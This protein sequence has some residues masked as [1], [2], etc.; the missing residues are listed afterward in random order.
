MWLHRRFGMH[1]DVDDLVQE[2]FLR[3]VK[4]QRL[5]KIDE[6]RP[7]LFA[8]AY[9][10]AIDLYRRR[11][12]LAVGGVAELDALSVV[13]EAGTTAAFQ[14]DGE[15]MAILVEAI[16]SLPRR[17]RLVLKLRK[18]RGLS[19]RDIAEQLG[20]SENTVHAHVEKGVARCR[21]YFRER[22]LLRKDAP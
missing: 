10:T 6:V 3:V 17:C 9:N 19:H 12:T 1:S 7:Y 16:E 4:G 20:I 22:G 18:L 5:K 2:T 21:K 8:V 13:E 15:K 11:K 14:C